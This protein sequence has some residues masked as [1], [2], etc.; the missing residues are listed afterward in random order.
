MNKGLHGN[1]VNN[2][3]IT[4]DVE[5][6]GSIA[7]A[8]N[9]MSKRLSNE[10]LSDAAKAGATIITES[11][12]SRVPVKTGELLDSLGFSIEKS[13]KGV[14]ATVGFIDD[15]QASIGYWVEHGHNNRQA[16]T[17]M[18]RFFK[19][20]GTLLGMVPAHPFFRPGIDASLKESSQA[21]M[22]V[23]SKALQTDTG[24]TTTGK[25]EEAA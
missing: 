8:L 15:F 9:K 6:T 22:E 3:D 19:K 21:V 10:V 24:T 23:L 5:V 18:Q 20:K 13:S 2:Q 11:I 25:E 12:A 16:K 14:V 4:V 17:A 7:E 1:K